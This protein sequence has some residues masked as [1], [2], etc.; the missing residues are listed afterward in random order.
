MLKI[1]PPMAPSMVLFGEIVV[2]FFPK[3]FLPKFLPLKYAPTSAETTHNTVINVMETPKVQLVGP[4]SCNGQLKTID[5]ARSIANGI[6]DIALSLNQ[7]EG[8]NPQ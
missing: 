7:N 6:P 8:K 1:P 3:N 4:P 2:N 5:P